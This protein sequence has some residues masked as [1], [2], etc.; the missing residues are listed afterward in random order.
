MKYLQKIFFMGTGLFFLLCPLQVWSTE[1]SSKKVLN[2]T[3]DLTSIRIESPAAREILKKDYIKVRK[4]RTEYMPAGEVPILELEIIKDEDNKEKLKHLITRYSGKQFRDEEIKTSGNIYIANIKTT[5]Y[6]ISRSS[7]SYKFTENANSMTT[8]TKI[9]DFKQAV[10]MALD[11][12]GRQHLIELT[13]GEDADILFVSAVKNVLTTVDEKKGP[14]KPVEE[15]TSDYYVGFGRRYKGIPIWGSQLII[16][17]DGEGNVASVQKNWRKISE[18]SSEKA[19]IS[20]KTLDQIILSDPI[21]YKKYSEKP[22]N[23][24][25][26]QIVDKKCGYL[27]APVNYSQARLRPGCIVSFKISEKMDETYPQIIIP[28]EDKINIEAL[29]GKKADE[30]YSDMET[31]MI[32]DKDDIEK[33]EDK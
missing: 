7:G 4:G 32:R 1:D 24:K 29:W 16:R 15:F 8:P 11:Y 2:E 30:K 19:K 9:K 6:W 28:L 10:Q 17:L 27:E 21:F 26:I 25:D 12:L 22:L 23:V 33:D 3:L 18:I 13:E 14:E 31:K 5:S 20:T